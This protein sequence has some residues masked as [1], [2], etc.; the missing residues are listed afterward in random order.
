MKEKFIVS[1]ILQVG[2]NILAIIAGYLLALNLDVELIGILALLNSI[3]NIGFIFANIGITSIHYQYSSK[4]NFDDYFGTFFLLQSLIIILNTAIT[5]LLLTLFQ[6]WNTIYAIYFIVILLSKIITQLTQIYSTNLRTKIKVFKVEIPTFLTS[7]G[8]S[9]SIIYL[10]LNISRFSDPLLYLVII[11]FTFNLIFIIVIVLL[12]RNHCKLNKPKKEYIKSYFRDAKPLILVSIFSILTANLGNI[13]LDYSFGHKSLAYF[14]IINNNIIPI[15]LLIS[16]ALVPLY[17]TLYSK[18]FKEDNIASI[19]EIAHTVEKYSSIFF[20]SIIIVVFLV[21]DLIFMIFLPK[22]LNS[23]MILQILVLIPYFVS[24][25]RPYS[26]MIPGK[27]QDYAAKL[28]FITYSLTL[29]LLIVLIPEKFFMFNMLGLGI[30]GYT[31][32]LLIPSIIHLIAIRYFAF[33]NFKLCSQKSIFLHFLCAVAAYLI[34]FLIKV[35]Y[36]EHLIS[37]LFLLLILSIFISLGIFIGLLF[38]FKQLKKIDIIFLLDLLK[39][40]IYKKS[41]LE[42]FSKK[43][44]NI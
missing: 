37:N 23:V 19:E 13:I 36:L 10:S 8:K 1:I 7:I 20:L 17:I 4:D 21:G 29:I 18:Y 9:C 5:L 14:A 30:F 3:V 12:A 25:D 6:I 15:L 28:N 44:K 35:Y 16:G 32:A 34:S 31:L 22:Y 24:L 39:I 26:V 27:R 2:F 43:D 41:F 38:I 33:K 40:K 42:E 11:N